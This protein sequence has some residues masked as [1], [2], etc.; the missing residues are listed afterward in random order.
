MDPNQH[1]SDPV[2]SYL[3]TDVSEYQPDHSETTLSLHHTEH[4]EHLILKELFAKTKSGCNLNK[5][6]ETNFT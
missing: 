1:T 4:P 6:V 5:C 3:L 2:D